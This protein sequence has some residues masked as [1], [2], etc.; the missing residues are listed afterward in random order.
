MKD[1]PTLKQWFREYNRRYFGNRLPDTLVCWVELKGSYGRQFRRRTV[2]YRV[3]NGK[4]KMFK[5]DRPM[6]FISAVLLRKDW[7]SVARSTLL[8]EMV[9]L[10][11][12]L[13]INHGPRF[14]AGMLRIA[15][16]GAFKG[17][18]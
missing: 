9:H 5:S 1:N 16:A 17:L 7:V 14:Q 15:K 11:L 8:H 10:S 6:I 4:W 13:R 2:R 18:W 12:P 3:T